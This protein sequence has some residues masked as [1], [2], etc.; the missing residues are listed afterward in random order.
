M[1][2]T[3]QAFAV[4]ALAVLPGALYTWSFERVVGRWGSGA[5]DRVFRFTGSSAMFLAAYAYP[6]Y[7]LWTNYLHSR[8]VVGGVVFYR[9]LLWEGRLLPVWLFLLPIAYVAVPMAAGTFAGH[10]VTQARRGDSPRWAF[11]AR[12]MAGRAPAP[13]AWDHVFFGGLEAVV[14]VRLQEGGWVGGRFGASSYAAGY[15]ETPQDLYLEEAFIINEDGSFA[16]GDRPDGY[17][18]LGS[19]VLVDMESAVHLELFMPSEETASD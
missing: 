17:A 14:R 9:N 13:R 7:L 1:P 5:A 19:G 4:A 8:E 6:A 16:E 18:S 3:F 11:A 10:A 12:V 2:D 15:G